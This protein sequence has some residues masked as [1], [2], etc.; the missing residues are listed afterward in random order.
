MSAARPRSSAATAFALLLPALL[1]LVFALHLRS[2]PQFLDFHLHY[3]PAPPDAVVRGLVAHGPQRALLHD[4]HVIAYLALPLFLVTA[5]AL[6]RRG[7][8]RHPRASACACAITAIGTIYLGGV[9]G[10]WTAFY[11]GLSHVDPRDIDGATAA[12]AAMTAPR[13]AFL[14]TT[15]LA[16]L[17]F[18][19]LLLQ[20]LVLWSPARRDR[21]AASCI[22]L[23]S[24]L[25]LAFW[26]LD[27]WMLVGSVLLL[28]GLVAGLGAGGLPDDARSA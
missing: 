17:A 1:V 9:F 28:A 22:A 18:T 13:G 2:L 21:L 3:Q 4:P 23:G 10:M 5:L 8:V 7:R 6:H 25:F 24:A 20:G 14:L 11:D 27:N 12:F 19:G 26:D 16:K 15:S